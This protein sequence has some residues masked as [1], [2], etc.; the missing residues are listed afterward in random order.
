MPAEVLDK[1]IKE[2]EN[3]GVEIKTNSPVESLDE[4]FEQGYQA[5]FVSV[6]AHKGTGIGVE[7]ENAP[8]VI[9]GV[10]FLRGVTLG[11]KV[12]VGNRVLVVGG[13]NVAIDTS[14]TAL[15][16]GAKEVTIVY[17]RTRTEMPASEEEK[18]REDSTYDMR[19]QK[20][21]DH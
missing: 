16:L 11:E 1:E 5:V 12:D 8:G 19:L 6:G 4:L 7:G 9:D 10:D 20:E 18:K 3:I 14:R 2:I 13:G 17:R 21:D 15:R